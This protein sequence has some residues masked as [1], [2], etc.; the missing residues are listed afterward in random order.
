MRLLPG[1]P[2]VVL[3]AVLAAFATGAWASGGASACPV[4]GEPV[5]WIADYCLARVQSDD[6]IAAGPCMER[7]TAR[8]RRLG[9]CAIKKR[10]KA[11][12]CQSLLAAGARAGSLAACVSDPA[13]SGK[14][15][16][17]NGTN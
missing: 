8:V 7:E 3:G 13:F 17:D 1:I 9:A 12:L 16:R 5:Q 14:I 4:P 2:R 10:Y 6:L 11:R 15:V